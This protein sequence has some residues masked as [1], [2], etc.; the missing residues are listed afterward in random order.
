MVSSSLITKEKVELVV[1]KNIDL[2]KTL[3]LG[4]EK[5][6]KESSR[7]PNNSNPVQLNISQRSKVV[8]EDENYYRRSEIVDE[9]E[10]N[11]FY[12]FLKNDKYF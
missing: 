5:K 12:L 3:E 6:D 1:A 8:I 4:K 9:T 10:C 7:T 2:R 11:S